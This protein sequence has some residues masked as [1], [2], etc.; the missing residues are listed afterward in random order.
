MTQPSNWKDK[1][2]ELGS[3]STRGAAFM[4]ANKPLLPDHLTLCR[5]PQPDTDSQAS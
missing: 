5:D 1:G 2:F 3:P 4:T